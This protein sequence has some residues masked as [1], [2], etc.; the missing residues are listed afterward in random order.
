MVAQ[1]FAGMAFS[2]AILGIDHSLS[3]KISTIKTTHGRCNAILMPA[4]IQYNAKVAG[5]RYAQIAKYLRVAGSTDEELVAFLVKAVRDLN[6]SLDIP[7]RFK[8]L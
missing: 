2:N 7:V 5:S 6:A 3:H 8:E 4:V 1:N